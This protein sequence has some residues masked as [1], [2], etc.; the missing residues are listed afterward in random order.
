MPAASLSGRFI[1]P[2]FILLSLCGCHNYRDLLTDEVVLK[3]KNSHTGTIEASDS[4]QIKLRKMDESVKMIPWD[5]VDTVTGKKLKTLWIGANLGYYNTPYFSVFRNES[6]TGHAFGFQGKLG[7]ATWGNR[8]CY[9][10]LTLSPA[11]PYKITKTG[12]GYQRYLRKSTYLAR[13]S[14]F[15][16]GEVNAMNAKNN[17]GVQMTLEPFLGFE[18]KL[19][20]QVRVNF[21]FQVQINLANKNNSLGS[22]FSIGFHFMQKNF[23]NRYEYLNTQHRLYGK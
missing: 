14:F 23:V 1:Y 5:E 21:K 6:L 7:L 8:L 13:K 19:H 17:N 4:I 16:G 3:D 20:E 2:V 10:G 12:I 11:S 15:A 18:R 9:F 22:S